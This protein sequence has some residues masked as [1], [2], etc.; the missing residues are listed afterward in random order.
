MT[1]G[2]S[3]GLWVRALGTE[4]NPALSL[5]PFSLPVPPSS[6]SLSLSFRSPQRKLQRQPQRAV[7][8]SALCPQHGPRGAGGGGRWW[9]GEA[10]AGKGLFLFG[11]SLPGPSSPPPGW[12]DSR[13]EEPSSWPPTSCPLVFW[14]VSDL[15]A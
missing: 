1:A 13:Q 3:A 7:W 6:L 15:M 14:L 5:L 8:T 10:M 2:A 9:H 12:G 4:C 11:L